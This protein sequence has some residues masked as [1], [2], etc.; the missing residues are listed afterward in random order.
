MKK[1]NPTAQGIPQPMRAALRCDG[2]RKARHFLASAAAA[3]IACLS[4]AGCAPAPS[5]GDTDPDA[6]RIATTTPPL[7]DWARQVA[8][9]DAVVTCILPPGS[10]AHTFEPSPRE[11]RTVA[12]ARILLRVGLQLDNWG[13]S[14]AD[15]NRDIHTVALGDELRARNLLPDVTTITAAAVSIGT[16]DDH[17]GHD[18]AAGEGDHAAD[19]ESTT[20]AHDDS[21]ADEHDH[22]T[23]SG[24][25][26]DG[27]D[28]HFWLDPLVARECVNLI[29]DHLAAAYPE[30][31]AEFRANAAR[32][33]DELMALDG[34]IRETLSGA[35]RRDFAT[36]HNAFAYYASR[37]GL[38]IA[39]VI[40]EYPGKEPGDRY[41]KAVVGKLRDA[42]IRRVFAEPQFSRRAAEIIA[43]E[44]GGRVEIL[45]PHGSPD[46][47][48]RSNY[49]EL[50][51]FNTRAI[52][53]ALSDS[54]PAP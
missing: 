54:P 5:A 23:C 20:A 45:D 44:I 37:Y 24:H 46:V 12:E 26:H 15:A 31:A 8:G 19:A 52:A 3:L 25:A 4:L 17:T 30:R 39:A 13:K 1:T 14:L 28:P 21:N 35:S 33:G 41:L 47:P 36:F 53:G 22:A 40:E 18:H 11:M 43:R 49:L 50:M 32:Y 48:E 34:E 29:A 9:P 16:A 42:G 2:T 6:V 7:A 51:R 38:T 10:N 27:T